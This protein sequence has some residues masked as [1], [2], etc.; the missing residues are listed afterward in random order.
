[1]LSFLQF[2]RLDEKISKNTEV[3][4]LTP[5][6][7]YQIAK[8]EFERKGIDIDK[9]FPEFIKH[10][11]LAKDRAS[12]GYTKRKNMPVITTEQ[13]KAFQ[14]RLKNGTV[15]FRPP[16]SSKETSTN[17][18]PEGLSGKE[19]QR[20]LEAGLKKFDG[21]EN[22]D[23]VKSTLEKV[24]VKNLHPIQ[25]QIYYNK[26]LTFFTNYSVEGARSYLSTKPIT[27]IS[28]DGYIIDGHHRFVAAI[29]L[30]PNLKVN[31]LR[32]QLNIKELLPLSKAYGDAIGNS[33]NH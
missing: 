16:Y 28:K 21:D 25:Q 27:I 9:D 10:F 14:H 33:R 7:A 3:V 18:F 1:M 30:D 15:D 6:R 20:F 22:D 2:Y 26:A 19:A 31:V 13:V 11:K 5:E 29:L 32:V 17:P 8:G 12:E 23:K 4:S 24:A